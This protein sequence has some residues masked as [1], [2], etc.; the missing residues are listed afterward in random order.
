MLSRLRS[1]LHALFGRTRFEQDMDDELRFHIDCRTEELVRTGLPGAEAER[2]ARIDFGSREAYKERSR[3]QLRLSIFDGI[4]RDVR[5]GARVLRRNPGLT[6][7][8]CLTL[9]LAIGANT[10]V[11][12][13]AYS[14]LIRPLPYPSPDRLVRLTM[15]DRRTGNVYDNSLGD[16]EDFRAGS[17]S[18][19]DLGGYIS[20]NTDLIENGLA[21]PVETSDITPAALSVL[22]VR[23]LLGRLFLPEEDR[24]GGDPHKTVI[25]Y[26]LW[27]KRFGGDPAIVGK[28]IRTSLT[29]LTIVGVMPSGF[30]F[31]RRTELW[32]PVQL[33]YALNS[34][35][36]RLGNRAQR[37]Y[38]VIARL[39]PGVSLFQAKQDLTETMQRLGELYPATNS[40]FEPRLITLREAEAGHFRPYL[41]ML[42]GAASFVL[43]LCCA[44]IANLL[45]ARA[46]GRSRELAVRAALGADRATIIRQLLT[47]SVLA[48]ILGGLIGLVLALIGLRFFTTLIP[49][50]LPAWI[51]IR[52][53]PSVLMFNVVVSIGT[54]L[55]AGLVPALQ[56]SPEQLREGLKDAARGSSGGKQ[57]FRDTLVI[58]Q[59]AL[60]VVLLISATLTVKSFLRL[61]SS[62]P[63]FDTARIVTAYTAPYS[64]GN[65]QQQITTLANYY[66]NAARELEKLPG[67]VA[68]GATNQLPFDDH[69]NDRVYGPIFIRG[70]SDG[71]QRPRL[72]ATLAVAS[73]RYLEALGARIIEGRDFTDLD[74]SQ[75]SSVVIISQSAAAGLWPGQDP[76]GRELQWRRGAAVDPWMTVIGVTSDIRYELVEKTSFQVYFPYRQ[77]G[78]DPGHF[79]VRT[80]G[81]PARL[82]QAVR[83]TIS[84]VDR[85]VAVSVQTM[86]ELAD[87]SI[88]QQRLSGLVTGLFA[89]LALLL[90]TIGIYGLLS[91]SVSQ[92]AREIGIRVALG[93]GS[94]QVLSAVLG[95]GARL[96]LIG[97]AIG[98]LAAFAVTRMMATLLYGVS[99][100]DRSTFLVVPLV[101]AAISMVACFIPARRATQVDPAVALRME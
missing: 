72:S 8:L 43:L 52:L 51:Q 87:N 11:F 54:G 78:L 27:R 29:T 59:I 3:E 19:E 26:A 53:H 34:N 56:N 91:Y 16:L 100:S 2:Q 73:P 71:E 64:K 25:S 1:L 7:A 30:G 12:E 15:L 81:D 4:R 84:S 98:L 75:A 22:K 57:G 42:M 62:T 21:Q 94:R 82:L 65:R 55:L 92:R 5:Y 60:S 44:N 63:G 69:L 45:L 17:R 99:V 97:V 83:I 80:Q 39:R 24:P 28:A 20:Y 33:W 14:I 77:Q 101:L 37:P 90:A 6:I 74:T 67:V 13:L 32:T 85:E 95:Q 66:Q 79:V 40:G 47:E 70:A 9:G 41:L 23:P 96:T 48:S 93:A 89:G 46:A 61:R 68:V 88:W 49:V 50:P 76:L 58:C 36:N 10:A 35:A 18:F 38:E 31:P 86:Q